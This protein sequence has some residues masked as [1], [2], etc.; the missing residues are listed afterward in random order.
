MQPCNRLNRN[1]ESTFPLKM[2]ISHWIWTIVYFQVTAT[3]KAAA[4]TTKSVSKIIP[5][6]TDSMNVSADL[7]FQCC[8]LRLLLF[9]GVAGTHRGIQV[10]AVWYRMSL[11]EVAPGMKHPPISDLLWTGAESDIMSAFI[12]VRWDDDAAWLLGSERRDEAALAPLGGK[13]RPLLGGWTDR[14]I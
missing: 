3:W 1:Q 5:A 10:F 12:A 14:Q 9:L 8:S 11:R 4:C 2:L 7:A 6:C 13:R